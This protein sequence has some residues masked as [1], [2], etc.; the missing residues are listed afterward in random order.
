[1]EI[2]KNRHVC[3]TGTTRSA[4]PFHR[5]ANAPSGSS[6]PACCSTWRPCTRRWAP[7]TTAGVWPVGTT[8]TAPAARR[9]RPRTAARSCL[10]R[11]TVPRPL[12]SVSYERPARTGTSATR[13]PT[14]R[15]GQPI[16]GPPAFSTR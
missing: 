12:R 4:G 16:S 3:R 13:S 7:N 9:Q 15:P 5:A 11:S 2:A 8:R 6:R 14:R 10:P 1:M